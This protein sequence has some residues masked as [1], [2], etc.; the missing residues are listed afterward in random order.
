VCLGVLSIIPIVQAKA[1]LPRFGHAHIVL[2][3]QRIWEVVADGRTKS[4]V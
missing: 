4:S 2:P 1:A 3:A